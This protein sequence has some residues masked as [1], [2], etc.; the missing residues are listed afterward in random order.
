M[1]LQAS[2]P[3]LRRFSELAR[4]LKESTNVRKET[5][6]SLNRLTPTNS[7]EPA[8]GLQC[9]AEQ[10]QLVHCKKR[11]PSLNAFPINAHGYRL[12]VAPFAPMVDR[13][14]KRRQPFWGVRFRLSASAVEFEEAP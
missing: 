7:E 2:F 13:G 3:G 14:K 5:C 6:L 8:E 1:E 9:G 10:T 11:G 4:C 12:I